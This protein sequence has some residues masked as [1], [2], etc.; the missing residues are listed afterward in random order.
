M[1]TVLKTQRRLLGQHLVT[2]IDR[3]SAYLL[4]VSTRKVSLRAVG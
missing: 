3:L 2:L 4:L 1:L